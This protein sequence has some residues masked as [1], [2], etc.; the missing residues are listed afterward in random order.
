MQTLI[1]NITSEHLLERQS[2]HFGSAFYY[3]L[4][5]ADL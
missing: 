3:L 1:Q 5:T 2:S 4:E